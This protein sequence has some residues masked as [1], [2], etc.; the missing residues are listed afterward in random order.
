MENA[1]VICYE[2]KFISDISYVIFDKV[3][4]I[5]Y[6]DAKIIANSLLVDLILN[7]DRVKRDLGVFEE[8]DSCISIKS[9]VKTGVFDF[10][11][12]VIS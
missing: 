11:R 12:H 3:F 1:Y 2:Y 10:E 7:T 5:K 8:N 4:N 9:L 6:F